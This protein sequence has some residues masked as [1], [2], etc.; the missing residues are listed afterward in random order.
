MCLR[1]KNDR[2]CCQEAPFV[3]YACF[4]RSGA[5]AC[6]KIRCSEGVMSIA[7]ARVIV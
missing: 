4:L 6:R 2:G 7:A 5:A 3:Y 1:K